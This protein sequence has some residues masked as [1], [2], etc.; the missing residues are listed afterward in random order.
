MEERKR[1]Y[2]CP[3]CGEWNFPKERIYVH[4]LVKPVDKWGYSTYEF[5]EQSKFICSKCGTKWSESNTRD[6]EWYHQDG[7]TRTRIDVFR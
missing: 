4:K 3:S 1:N 5:I 2:I 6:R 7:D